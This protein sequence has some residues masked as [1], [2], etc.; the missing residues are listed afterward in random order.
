MTSRSYTPSSNRASLT[1][2]EITK[3]IAKRPDQLAAYAFAAARF[4]VERDGASWERVFGRVM[5]AGVAGGL[6]E[7]QARHETFRGF[8]F[9]AAGCPEPPA[10][11][12][13]VEP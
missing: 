4:L 13:G 5:R 10:E 6:P 12:A 3:W 11:L 9:C 2:D 1:L 7:A 8:A